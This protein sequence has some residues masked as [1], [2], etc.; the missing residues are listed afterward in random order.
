[1]TRLNRTNTTSMRRAFDDVCNDGEPP[2][3]TLSTLPVELLKHVCQFAVH[4]S[5]Q[6][7]ATAAQLARVSHRV[8]DAMEKTSSEFKRRCDEDIAEMLAQKMQSDAVDNPHID[9]AC[10]RR[11]VDDD[12]SH[13]NVLSV[14]G[15]AADES[16]MLLWI[17]SASNVYPMIVL[18][19][20]RR[21]HFLDALC[22]QRI[23]SA[24]EALCASNDRGT[25]TTTAAIRFEH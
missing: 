20:D 23:T 15:G 4:R 24:C 6:R 21:R 5:T 19:L 25:N 13:V 8:N 18:D 16:Y 2:L 3:P 14:F 7:Y 12:R 1:L 9:Y 17:D 11:A 22:V 10:A